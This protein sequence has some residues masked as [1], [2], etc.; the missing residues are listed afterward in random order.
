[1]ATV[2]ITIDGILWDKATKSGRAVRLE[3]QGFYSDLSVGGGPMPGGDPPQIWGPTDPRPTP[4]IHLGPGGEP[5][6]PVIGGGPIY[7]G[8]PTHPIVIPPGPEAPPGT[9]SFPISGPPG[10]VFPPVPGYPPVVG[11]GPIVGVPPVE[12]PPPP[13]GGDKPPPESGGWGFVAEWGAWGYF[14]APGQAQ[15]K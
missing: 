5:L 7:P 8:T 10:I 2:A 9:P 11:G 4:P 3:G 14:P 13:D 6:P 12:I 1:M 15:P